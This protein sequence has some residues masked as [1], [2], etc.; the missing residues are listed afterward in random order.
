MHTQL[1]DYQSPTL[2]LLSKA[3]IG[4]SLATGDSAQLGNAHPFSNNVLGNLDL[5]CM[6]YTHISLFNN[7]PGNLGLLPVLSCTHSPV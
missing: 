2:S 5:R 7:V 6:V 4:H 1:C 3:S